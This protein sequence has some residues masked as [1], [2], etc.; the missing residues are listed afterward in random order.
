DHPAPLRE[1]QLVHR[2]PDVHARVVDEDV[3]TP[4]AVN[5]SRNRAG[6]RALI[7]DVALDRP[8][9][10]PEPAQLVDGAAALLGVPARHHDGGSGPGEPARPAATDAPRASR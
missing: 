2:L 1:R 7:G 5:R 3:E 9:G 8:R 10:G 4:E 6:D